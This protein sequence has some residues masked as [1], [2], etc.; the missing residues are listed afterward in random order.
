MK[1]T[2]RYDKTPALSGERSKKQKQFCF[3]IAFGHL[4]VLRRRGSPVDVRSFLL[5]GFVSED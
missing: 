4:S 5:F 1:T 3:H 2:E